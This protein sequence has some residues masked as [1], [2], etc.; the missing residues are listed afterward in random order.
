MTRTKKNKI[1]ATTNIAPVIETGASVKITSIDENYYFG[2]YW[3]NRN[4]E[5][6]FKIEEF[7]KMKGL[8]LDFN[9]RIKK[10]KIKIEY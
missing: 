9:E 3:L 4:E 10:G 1:Q 8:C 2:I 7:E 5:R 6:E